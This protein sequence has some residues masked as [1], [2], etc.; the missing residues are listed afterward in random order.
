MPRLAPPMLLFLAD[1]G[2]EVVVGR[3]GVSKDG[4][5]TVSAREKQTIDRDAWLR[6]RGQTPRVTRL[7]LF[8]FAQVH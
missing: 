4:K 5:N 2:M 8:Y 7:I 1:E 3:Y 6:H